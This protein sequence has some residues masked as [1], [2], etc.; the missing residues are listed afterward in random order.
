VLLPGL[1]DPEKVV[2]IASLRALVRV[3]LDPDTEQLLRPHRAEYERHEIYWATW[4][5]DATM[6]SHISR[7]VDASDAEEKTLAQRIIRRSP[8]NIT[9]D[10]AYLAL[11]D[12]GPLSEN[13]LVDA[14]FVAG[15]A[16][17]IGDQFVPDIPGLFQVYLVFLRRAADFWFPYVLKLAEKGVFR[18]AA[19]MPSFFP[20]YEGALALPARSNG[21]YRVPAWTGWSPS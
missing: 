5:P 18:P 15:R 10:F 12:Y 16:A 11:H 17:S 2:R 21:S 8:S 3:P 7:V 13:L 14:K 20:V 1:S 19:A 4:T 9:R 6:C